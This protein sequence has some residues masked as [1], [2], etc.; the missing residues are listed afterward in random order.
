MPVLDRIEMNVLHMMPVVVIIPDRVLPGTILPEL[1]SFAEETFP[2]HL[3]PEFAFECESP[4]RVVRTSGAQ[5]PMDM[6]REWPRLFI[7][8]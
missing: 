8:L 2:F 3:H 1:A 5:E 4:V 6:V 7:S